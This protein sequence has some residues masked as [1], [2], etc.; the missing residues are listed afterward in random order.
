ML[1]KDSYTVHHGG[2]QLAGAFLQNLRGARTR[3]LAWVVGSGF[4]QQ[5]H[6]TASNTLLQVNLQADPA[7]RFISRTSHPIH[8]CDVPPV[9]KGFAKLRMAGHGE[10]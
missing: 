4:A 10:A 8:L 7:T 9:C 2:P 1:W 3:Y 5:H 6:E